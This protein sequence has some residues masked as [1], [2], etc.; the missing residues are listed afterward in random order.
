MEILV[1]DD[2]SEDDTA[3]LAE[4]FDDARIRVLRLSDYPDLPQQAYKKLALSTAIKEAKGEL[5]VTTDADCYMGAQWLSLLVAYYEEQDAKMIAAPVCMSD[6]KSLLEKFQALDFCGMMGI[7]GAGVSK[8]YM[9]MGNGANI[10]YPKKIFDAVNGF[11]GIDHLASGDDMLLMQKIAAAYPGQVHFL[12]NAEAVVY[13]QAQASWRAFIQQRLRWASKSSAYPQ[14]GV[15]LQLAVVYLYCW[16]MLL[17][18]L[19]IPFW[20]FAWT[21]ALGQILVKIIVDYLLLGTMTTFFRRPDLMR[22][23]LPSQLLHIAYI[24]GIGTLGNL[25]KRYEWKGRRV[26]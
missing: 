4:A 20:S 12:K 6:E 10:A 11:E 24:V 14:K 5:I 13:T 2:H 1:I 25:V 17:S 26:S 19:L 8:G 16:N 18:V 22:V 15:T 21:I 7:T 9:L 3:A 23:F